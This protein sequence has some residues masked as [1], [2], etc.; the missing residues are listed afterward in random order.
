[1]SLLPFGASPFF[2]PQNSHFFLN[3]VSTIGAA[4]PR[5]STSSIRTVHPITTTSTTGTTNGTESGNGNVGGGGNP[6]GEGD[7][8]GGEEEEDPSGGEEEEDP[9]GGEEEEDPSGG[10]GGEEEEEED[11]IGGGEE[12]EEAIEEEDPN[13]GGST[14]P[15]SVLGNISYSFPELKNSVLLTES[16][17]GSTPSKSKMILTF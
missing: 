15:Y 8:S 2:F 3:Q 6:I 4:L 1:V 13:G 16:H 10:G 17:G 7:L 9:S 14:C 11:P 5:S 12:E